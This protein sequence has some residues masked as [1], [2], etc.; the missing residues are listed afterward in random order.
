MK[1]TF[2]QIVCALAL[3][4]LCV[5]LSGD[6]E[7]ARAALQ[8]RLYP[9]AQTHAELALRNG[10]AEPS[11]ALL[12]LLEALA[13]QGLYAEMLN[14]LDAFGA[15]VS[16]ARQPEAFRYWRVLALL[17][18]GQLAEA[19]RLAEAATNVPS[20]YADAMRC[21]GARAKQAAGDLPGALVLFAEVD[22]RSTN[23]LTRAANALEWAMALDHAGRA[24]AALD[25]LKMQAGLAVAGDAMND[26]ALLRGRILMRSGKTVE[27]TMVF[28]QLAMSER[29]AEMARVQA[30][31]EMSVFMWSGGKT[32]EAVAY[33]RS[34]YERAQ[35]PETRR[36]AGF[37]L[38][39][40]LA[41]DAA[42]IDEGEGLVKALVREFSEHPASMLAQLKLADSL[43]QAKR[44]ERAA[45]EYRIFLETYPSSSLDAAVLQGR[46]WAL[47][48]LGRF[49]EA[50]G[51]FQRAAEVAT[52][53]SVK[54]EC[55]FKQGDALLADA[56]FAEASQVYAKLAE[57]YPKNVYADRALFQ[58]ADCLERA[59]KRA[60]A[61]VQYRKVAEKYPEREVAP[62]ALL[63]LASLQSEA[64]E[65][66]EAVR[67]YTS[68][69]GA[70]NQKTVRVDAFMGRGKVCYRTYRFDA[71][72]QD[73]AAVAESD[74]ARRD[75]ARFLLTLCLYGLGRDK[76]ARAAA[77][78]FL[79][80]F[81]ESSRLSDMMLW[82]GKFDFNRKKFEDA[83]RFFLEYVARWPSNRWADAALLWAARAAFGGADFTGT[84]ELV[85]RL[86]RAY[87]QSPRV[88]E[89]LLVQADA[90]MELARFDEAVLLLDQVIGQA[91]DSEWGK[92]ALMRKG[93]CLFALGA[94]NGARYQEALAAY[95]AMLEQGSRTPA[96]TL[97][98][99]FKAGRCLEK[100]KRIDDAIDQY[101]S[102][103]M[104][105]YQ[106]ERDSGAWYD[107]TSTSLFVRAAL[108]VA[109]LYEQKGQPEQAV[110][111]L[112]R[113]VQ[114][115]V[116]GEEEVRQRIERLRKKKAG[117]S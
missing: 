68:V 1:Q 65:F 15:V 14:R 38:G 106:N 86:V 26:G 11:Q 92:M 47:M 45:T 102:E 16:R 59:G 74:P 54:T 114:A 111:I 88:P 104:I 79:L 52:N 75:E 113:V 28:N 12:V 35:L 48:Q 51:S 22:K 64:G 77:V 24:D 58:S 90:L 115:G 60:E 27:A 95:R 55:L 78:S 3:W 76:E 50:G 6:L 101:Y 66:D 57:A 7:T 43:L 110:R 19:I 94:D 91:P 37:R 96:L 42:T 25:V 107:E 56:R 23:L 30:L 36:L 31:V 33:A 39:D 87:P 46:G 84:V 89:A 21:M 13:G 32:N 44:P 2:R 71:A 85:T 69:L 82:L 61:V 9:I 10:T 116:P 53:V 105:R 72:M 98:L 5:A 18:A 4:P 63:R 103:V 100:M 109:E 73:F 108:N 117:G 99:H 40:L 41:A 34:A 8:D 17:N 70:F 81:P 97:Q 112:Q 20:V 93:D 67:T 62:K 80:D 49:T 29:V 83:R